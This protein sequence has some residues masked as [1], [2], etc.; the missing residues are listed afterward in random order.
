MKIP[1]VG[2]GGIRSAQDVVEFLMAGASAVQIGTWNFRDPFVY[3][4]LAKDLAA[5]MEKRSYKSIK[6]LIGLAHS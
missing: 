3:Q 5:F 6:D 4:S 2:M 1:I